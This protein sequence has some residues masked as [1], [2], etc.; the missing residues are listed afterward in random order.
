MV[1]TEDVS[2]FQTESGSTVPLNQLSLNWGIPGRLPIFKTVSFKLTDEYDQLQKITKFQMRDMK[3]NVTIDRDEDGIQ[4]VE[5]PSIPGCVSQGQTKEEALENIKDAQTHSG[6]LPDIA[7]CL[8]TRAER[9][10]PLTVQTHQVEV[11]P[12]LWHLF[13]F[14]VGVKSSVYLNGT[15]R[16]LI[17][18]AGLT[19]SEFVS[20][21]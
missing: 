18:T 9:G 6:L 15:L 11:V 20:A 2:N 14:S 17:R 16:S 13:Q 12:Q 3:F 8:R 7:A 21:L 10:L 19:V 4:I 5:C 1:L